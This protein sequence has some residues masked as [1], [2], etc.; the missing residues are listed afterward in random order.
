[1]CYHEPSYPSLIILSLPWVLSESYSFT[2][3]LLNYRTNAPLPLRIPTVK[4]IYFASTE[5]TWPL[6]K[7][8]QETLIHLRKIIISW[9]TCTLNRQVIEE[10]DQIQLKTVRSLQYYGSTNN[11]DYID[12]FLLTPNLEELTIDG[13][14]IDPINSYAEE[15]EEIS[16]ICEQITRLNLYKNIGACDQDE[17]EENF[18]RAMICSKE[19]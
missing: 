7:F 6:I 10:R 18:P 1:M 2:D 9:F 13:A 8:L 3:H 15:N 11:S 14:A 16:S 4:S 17:T 19:I 5:I 12:F